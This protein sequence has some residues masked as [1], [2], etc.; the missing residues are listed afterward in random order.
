VGRH[1]QRREH[2]LGRIATG[3]GVVGAEVVQ[4][5]VPALAAPSPTAP[6]SD[7]PK[8]VE[9]APAPTP[10]EK[11]AKACVSISGEKAWLSD[12]QGHLTRAPVTVTTGAKDQRTP[13]GT[14]HVMWKDRYHVSR[15][16]GA[17][18]PYSVFFAPGDAL[19]TGKL[20]KQSSGCVHLGPDDAKAFFNDLQV[21]DEVQVVS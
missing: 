19:H 12:G 1:Q 9:D 11:A 7:D 13:L 3:V 4:A 15:E 5:A 16:S 6:S 8:P 20:D 21:N 2:R 14:F 17:T 18:M 10:C